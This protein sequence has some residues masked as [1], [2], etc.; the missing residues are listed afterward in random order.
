MGEMSEL[1]EA[2]TLALIMLTLFGAWWFV[3]ARVQ[4]R[5]ALAPNRTNS[6]R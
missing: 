1:I 6:T 3:S 4:K 5:D 2:A